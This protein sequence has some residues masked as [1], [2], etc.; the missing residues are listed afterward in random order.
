[1]LT[2]SSPGSASTWKRTRLTQTYEI[3]SQDPPGPFPFDL[4]SISC[5]STRLCVAGTDF[6]GVVVSTHPTAGASAWRYQRVVSG[7]HQSFD[8]VSCPTTSLC[9]AGDDEGEIGISTRPGA[10]R[11]AWKSFTIVPGRSAA[12][13]SSLTCPTIGLCVAAE[14]DGAI[15]TSTRPAAGPR[16]WRRLRLGGGPLTGAWC[17]S[18]HLCVVVGGGHAWTSTD[19]IGPRHDWHRVTLATDRLPLG[20]TLAARLR[21]V[22]CAPTRLCLAASGTGSVFPGAG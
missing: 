14:A 4:E 22:T 1:V 17:R 9:V 6:Q 21:A 19:P 16:A 7:D 10:R 18:A 8:T 12:G 3:D 20:A 5:S 2:S 13:I 15:D 11:N